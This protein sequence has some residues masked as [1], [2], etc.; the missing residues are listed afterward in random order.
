M[1][2]RISDFVPSSCELLAFG[3]PTHRE[4]GFA[5]IRNELFVEL[6]ARG[7]RS[8][9]LETDRVAALTVDEF[10]RGGPGTLDEVM[11]TGFSHEFGELAGNR[12]LVAWLRDYNAGRPV[13][14]QVH[15]HGF[16]AAMETMNAPSP[17]SYLEFARDYLELDFDIS[18][19]AGSDE[20]W[21]RTEAVLDAAVSP[22]ATLDAERLR[23]MADDMLALLY[24]RAPERIAATSLARW[25]TAAIH[26]TAGLGL[27]R[28]HRQAAA[29]T[30]DGVRW[31]S[32]AAARDA[33]MA[34]NLLDIRSTEARRGP[35]LVHSHNLHLRRTTSVMP[36]GP[37][38]LVWFGA[39]AIVGSLLGEHYRVILGSLGR[40]DGLELAEPAPGTYEH[41][42]QNRVDTW[43]LIPAAELGP[44]LIRI[45]ATREQ[46][47]FPLDA[48]T[49][50][51]ADTI[52]H[53]SVGEAP[54]AVS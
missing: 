28:Y 14:D 7:F 29:P 33:L 49:V 43:G 22:G 30:E 2:Q 38:E 50:G 53:L 32:L 20:R 23:A 17:R 19:P 37:M 46:G 54:T 4:P 41:V 8:I 18:G 9:A 42:L 24:A 40:S 11:R 27:L 25:R 51:A 15:F 12:N 34:Q 3:E 1:S 35:T 26:L 10:V 45:D 13:G 39:G 47:Y 52:L 44:A 31:N 6:V 21:S 48:D 16:D 5:A 36:M